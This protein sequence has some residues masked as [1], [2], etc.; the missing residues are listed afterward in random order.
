[1]ATARI[2]SAA[3]EGGPG[4]ANTRTA[5][6]SPSSAAVA[7]QEPLRPSRCGR[8]RTPVRA[9]SAR[10][11]SVLTKWAPPPSA[12]AAVTSHHGG[13]GEPGRPNAT[14]AANPP[15]ETRYGTG[16]ASVPFNGQL[17]A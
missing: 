15:K 8:P 7:S 12:A 2:A 16:D 1:I 4:G 6:D 5:V 14:N 13:A 9:S 10:S 17:Y 11:G 3:Q